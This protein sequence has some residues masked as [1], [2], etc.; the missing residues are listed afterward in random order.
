MLDFM[1]IKIVDLIKAKIRGPT[2]WTIAI[3]H[4]YIGIVHYMY[5]F[6]E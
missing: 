1:F 6:V 2:K 5:L 3:D 4:E